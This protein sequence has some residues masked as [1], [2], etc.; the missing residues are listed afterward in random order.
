MQI[1]NLTDDSF[2]LKMKN[3]YCR[4]LAYL[5]SAQTKPSLIFYFDDEDLNELRH[6]NMYEK[7]P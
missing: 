2:S 5:T 6:R 1:P 4:G 7:P 3:H